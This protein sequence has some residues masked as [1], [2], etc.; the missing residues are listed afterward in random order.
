MSADAPPVAVEGR[1]PQ[2]A[3]RRRAGR[4]R[5]ALGA[6]DSDRVD[7]AEHETHVRRGEPV[8]VVSVHFVGENDPA[9]DPV[10]HVAAQADHGIGRL[11]ARDGRAAVIEPEERRHRGAGGLARELEGADR[12]EQAARVDEPVGGVEVLH[13]LEKEGALFREE[14]GDSRVEGNLTG[15]RLDLREV[16]VGRA[17]ERQVVR[18]APAHR[19][20]ELRVPRLVAPPWGGRRAVHPFCGLGSDIEHEATPQAREP[21]EG[22]G[23]GQER[24]APPAGRRPRVQVARVLHLPEDAET[25]DL[26]VS[27]LVANALERDADLHLVA[28]VGD[29]ALRFVDEIRAEI[30]GVPHGAEVAR[31]PGDATLHALAQRAVRLHAE[32]V[33]P[34]H[35]RLAMVVEGVDQDLHVV[36]GRDLVA[37]GERR[38][39]RAVRLERP[40]AEVD[41]RRR[42]PHQHLRRV[43]GRTS[44]RRG[45]LREAGQDGRAVPHRLVQ[46]A[47]DGDQRLEMG[48]PHLDRPRDPGV[49]RRLGRALQHDR[50]ERKQVASPRPLLRR[51]IG[52]RRP[53]GNGPSVAYAGRW[54]TCQEVRG[55]CPTCEARAHRRRRDDLCNGRVA[56]VTRTPVRR[57][58]EPLVTR[59]VRRLSFCTKLHARTVP[60]SAL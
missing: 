50:E 38:V 19:R 25:P 28:V 37:V 29:P 18:D 21:G 51:R 43:L 10:A 7:A 8:V 41:G 48:D 6:L 33:R 35:Q 60:A 20:A 44:V 15:V 12:T 36:V 54:E 13:P 26:L 47:V 5:E 27:G 32:R 53:A 11:A 49:D 56:S 14:Q 58:T 3:T 4:P 24:G 23:L 57:V 31:Q 2:R 59:Q 52:A 46:C 40:H 16:R 42:V 17:A 9:G 45:V 55:C 39:H 22:P 30:H 34:E 1:L